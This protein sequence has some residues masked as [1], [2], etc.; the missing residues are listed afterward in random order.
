MGERPPAPPP[1]AGLGWPC[2]AGEAERHH[3]L[4]Q[5]I[6]CQPAPHRVAALALGEEVGPRPAPQSP[7]T[8]TPVRCDD[9]PRDSC[10]RGA[11]E[12]VGEGHS[13]RPPARDSGI[14]AGPHPWVALPP[15]I[16]VSHPRVCSCPDRLGPASAWQGNRAA[17]RATVT[18]PSLHPI[19]Q[20]GVLMW[21]KKALGAF[22]AAGPAPTPARN[23]PRPSTCGTQTPGAHSSLTD[24]PLQTPQDPPQTQAQTHVRKGHLCHPKG[25]T[26]WSGGP[27][28]RTM[29]A[30]GSLRS[31]P[32]LSK[33]SGPHTSP[34]EGRLCQAWAPHDRV[35]LLEGGDR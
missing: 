23:E 9:A 16:L 35:P 34:Q 5:G 28:R 7:G 33:A 4:G 30:C 1:S 31:R 29:G 12:R 13:V 20:L 19:P 10:L 8:C 21:D 15:S 32:V 14:R 27:N 2:Q 26:R 6:G 17:S 11:L 3:V 18:S 24:R 25:W 22:G